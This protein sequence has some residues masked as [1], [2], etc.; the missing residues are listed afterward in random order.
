MQRFHLVCTAALAIVAPLA[1]VPAGAWAAA[2]APSMQPP[3]V[4]VAA[5]PWPDGL[6]GSM[7]VATVAALEGDDAVAASAFRQAYGLDPSRSVL[8]R[9]AFLYSALAGDDAAA[10]LAA[11]LPGQLM[12]ELVMGNDAVRAGRWSDAQA[13]YD[14]VQQD[15][16]LAAIRPLLDAWTL[17]GAG[18]PDRALAIIDPWTADR[19]LG[20]YYAVHAALIADLAGQ[21]DRADR[22]YRLALDASP[23]RDLFSTW[24]LG[25]WLIAQGHRDQATRLLDSLVAGGAGLSLARDGVLAAMDRPPVTSPRQGIAQAYAFLSALIGQEAERIPDPTGRLAHDAG[26]RDMR[27]LLLRFALAL[28]PGFGQARLLLSA[29]QYDGGQAAAARDTIVAQARDGGVARA[30]PHDPLATVMQVQVARLDAATGRGDDAIRILTDLARAQPAQ[31]QIWQT[32]GDIQ[33]GREDWAGAAAS[34]SR[35]ITATGR[36]SGDDWEILFGRAVA[37]DRL[38][39]W[40]QAQADLEHAL[41]LAPNEALLLNYLGYSWVEHDRNLPQAEALLR[42]AVAVEPQNAA[43]RDSLGW[44][45]VRQGRIAE[46]LALLER[47]AEQTPEDPAV[48]YHLGVAY[49]KAGRPREAVNQ[50]HVAQALPAADPS[51]VQKITAA[52]ADAARSGHEDPPPD[53]DGAARKKDPSDRD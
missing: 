9:Q 45:L 22:Y 40:P 15:A 25:H 52:L 17:M 24:A 36:L 26:V 37:Y 42:H 8:L 28:D 49:W 1:A 23:G 48:N 29:L 30:F 53:Q 16:M 18:Q 43:I 46:G 21:H 34:F 33:S 35:A 4:T 38:A 7:L 14:R 5:A 50:W 10:G 39:R 51:D 27:M 11:R 3:A 31:A 12:A 41:A 13:H 2:P 20:R 32:L 19:V 6:S 44:A 47:A